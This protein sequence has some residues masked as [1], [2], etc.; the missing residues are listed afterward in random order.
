MLPF[1]LQA[2]KY[3][4]Y[5]KKVSPQWNV[6]SNHWFGKQPLEMT[7]LLPTRW[8]IW[9]GRFNAIL[10]TCITLWACHEHFF[11]LFLFFFYGIRT[12]VRDKMSH[13][14]R[15]EKR[16]QGKSI[17]LLKEICNK[18]QFQFAKESIPLENNIII[19]ILS[20]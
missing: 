5:E 12:Q 20:Y 11:F 10:K 15:Q 3:T 13:Q 8:V 4:F 16:K 6:V 18:E 2:L 9:G 19:V 17:N 14:G 7:L 1:C